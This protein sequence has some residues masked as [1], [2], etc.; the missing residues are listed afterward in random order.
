EY[1]WIILFLCTLHSVYSQN[2]FSQNTFDVTKYGAVG[3]QKTDDSRAFLKTWATACAANAAEVTIVVPQGKTFLVNTATFQGPCKAKRLHFQVNGNVVAPSSPSSYNAD[4]WFSFHRLNGLII[5][6][7]G[8]FDG[9]GAMWWKRCPIV[10]NYR[11][12]IFLDRTCCIYRVY[13]FPRSHFGL[14]SCSNVNITGV[15]ISAPASSPNTDGININYSSYIYVTDTQISV[16]DDCVAIQ[17]GSSHIYITRVTCGPGHGIS[18]G[19]LGVNGEKNPTVEEIHVRDSIINSA[20][21]GLRIKT[22]EGAGGYARHI[23]YYNVTVDSTYNPII[24]D[25]QYCPRNNCGNDS[26]KNEA[27]AVKISDVSFTKIKGTIKGNVGVMLNCST[28]VGCT[29][30]VLKDIDLK[31]AEGGNKIPLSMCSNAHGKVY[32]T[33]PPVTCVVP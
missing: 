25:Q 18:I 28:S 6:G 1:L 33:Q 19:S 27:N 22:W 21:N 32:N 3:N 4:S 30:L 24:I 12:I 15:H 29:G 17:S 8:Q 11:H 20:T 13:V 16:G 7:N 31:S 14:N 2:A 26:N 5:E 9:K 23:S 10:C